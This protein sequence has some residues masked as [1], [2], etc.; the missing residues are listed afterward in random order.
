MNDIVLGTRVELAHRCTD[1]MYRHCGTGNG[2][3]T[4][5]KTFVQLTSEEY[6]EIRAALTEHVFVRFD[7]DDRSSARIGMWPKAAGRTPTTFE[8][9]PFERHVLKVMEWRFSLTEPT[10]TPSQDF[11]DSASPNVGGL[12][13]VRENAFVDLAHN[14]TS[15]NG[16]YD[17]SCH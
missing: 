9:T 3:Y 13:P 10:T 15:T 4:V 5:A 16:D 8:T 17:L 12:E 11:T 1:R 2:R 14:D 7:R 6:A